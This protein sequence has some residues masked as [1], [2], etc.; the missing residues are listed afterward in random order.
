VRAARGSTWSAREE[1]GE[2]VTVVRL[3]NRPESYSAL[4]SIANRILLLARHFRA[5]ATFVHGECIFH[6]ARR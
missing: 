1:D 4:R 5:F 3:G 6:R 2:N